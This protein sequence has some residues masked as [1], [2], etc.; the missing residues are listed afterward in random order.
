MSRPAGSI[1]SGI[2]KPRRKSVKAGRQQVAGMYCGRGQ[3]S[4]L[5][6][7]RRAK[8][9][10]ARDLSGLVKIDGQA[11]RSGR[12]TSSVQDQSVS[13]SGPLPEP[14]I[15]PSKPDV[16]A[17]FMYIAKTAKSRC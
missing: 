16:V 7:P 6:E 2:S 8:G 15:K 17:H 3:R 12:A 14:L 13:K 5:R 11:G 9:A 4:R 10:L 1:V